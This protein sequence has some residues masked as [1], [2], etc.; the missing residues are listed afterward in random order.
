MKVHL[1][2]ISGAD[3]YGHET[4]Y[5]DEAGC[6]GNETFFKDIKATNVRRGEI[7]ETGDNGSVAPDVSVERDGSVMRFVL[8]TDAAAVWVE[9]N[10]PLESWQRL[11]YRCF[12]VDIRF[13][14]DLAQHMMNVGLTVRDA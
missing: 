11:G 5:C 4:K 8:N 7:Y 14:A 12:A 9:E 13:A 3:V 6:S 1:T 10:V 2:R